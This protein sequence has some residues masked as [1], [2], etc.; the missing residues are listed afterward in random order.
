MAWRW[1]TS[2]SSATTHSASGK[3]DLLLY[4]RPGWTSAIE[5][6]ARVQPGF[7]WREGTR[8]TVT[9]LCTPLPLAGTNSE[10]YYRAVRLGS[11]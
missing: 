2:Q 11:P 8:L 5:G 6:R 4:A 10:A 3:P 7:P 1:R 9:N